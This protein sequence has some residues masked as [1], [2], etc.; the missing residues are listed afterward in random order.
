MKVER[1]AVLKKHQTE[2][3][4]R[5]VEEETGFYMSIRHFLARIHTCVDKDNNKEWVIDS[6]C[7]LIY[8]YL[9]NFGK[10]HGW[11]NIYPNQD[12]MSV[13][14][15][16]KLSTLKRKVK[17]LGECG[18]ITIVKTKNSGNQYGSNRYKVFTPKT[19]PRRKWLDCEGTYLTGKIYEFDYKAFQRQVEAND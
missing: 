7:K 3:I 12:K 2:R 13:D 5:H 18:L 16:I 19:V 8:S 14:L 15:G 9:S 17:I 10:Q 4:N 11:H 6:D 1:V